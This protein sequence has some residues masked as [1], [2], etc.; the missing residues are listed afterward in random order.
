MG[1]NNAYACIIKCNKNF[2]EA[3]RG[4]PLKDDTMRARI[5][6]VLWSA[7]LLCSIANAQET[8]NLNRSDGEHTSARA[9][10]PKDSGAC[11]PLVI[12][13]PGA[14][15]SDRGLVGLANSFRSWGWLAVV[16]GHHESGMPALRENIRQ[17]G[18]RGGLLELVTDPGAYRGRLLDYEAIL[19]WSN[20][21]CTPPTRVLLGHSMGAASTMIEAGAKNKLGVSGGDRF[22]AYIAL[23]PQGIESIF[24]AHAWVG[25]RSPTL[26]ITGTKDQ[27]L[28]GS[29]EERTLPYEDTAPGCK[30]LVV[31]DGATHMN[32]GGYGADAKMEALIDGAVKTFADGVAKGNCRVPGK[33]EGVVVRSK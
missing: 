29:W 21:R 16:A 12:L 31:V 27:G 11:A 18:L 4:M 25:L 30:A 13:S 10:L 8:L 2:V 23:S 17:A 5:R 3:N 1:H 28:E 26:F 22:D 6:N 14:G 33:G 15:G 32:L 24:P 7:M 9:Y 20:K 19:A